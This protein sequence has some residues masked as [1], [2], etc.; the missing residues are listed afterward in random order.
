MKGLQLED[1][2]EEEYQFNRMQRFFY[3][4]V[5]MTMK[6]TMISVRKMGVPVIVTVVMKK[7]KT[8]ILRMK[9]MMWLA[10]MSLLP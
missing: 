8:K 7:V 4:K 9:L 3:L 10:K 6:K 2:V 1:L 5:Q